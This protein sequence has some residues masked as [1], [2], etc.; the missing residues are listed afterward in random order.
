MPK[1]LDL[2]AVEREELTARLAAAM[3]AGDE[4]EAAQAMAEFADTIQQRILAEA[5]A[6]GAEQSADKAVLASRGTRVLT[7]S[8]EKY[9]QQLITAMSG[10]T[11]KVKQALTDIEIAMPTTVIDAVFED[12]QQAHPLLNLVDFR[13]TNGIVK[14]IVNEGGIQLAVWGK[15]TDAFKTELSGGISEIDTSLYKLQA[16]L[17]V[18]KAMLDLGPVWLDRYV[19]AILSEAIAFGVED[20][21]VTGDGKD[22]PIGMTRV[23]GKQAVVSDGV[24]SEKEA[25]KITSIDPVSYGEICSKLAVHSENGRQRVVDNLILVVSPVDYLKKIMPATTMLVNGT[26]IRDIFPLPT[27]VA[28]SQK[29]PEGEAILGMAKRYFFALGTPKDGRIEYDDSVQFMEDARVYAARLY[30]NGRPLDNNAFLRL[31]ISE[32]KPL[33]YQVT[34]YAESLDMADTTEG[35]AEP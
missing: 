33:R 22:K 5:Q 25:L 32:L 31:D 20:A 23:V 15:L 17:P 30:G 4:T 11:H 7:S 29:C 13:N 34:T 14:M 18:A 24:Y 2:T 3:T 12:I 26:Y 28:Q 21:I 19:R 35:D 6:M 10:S 1:S 9:Y 27:T 16:Y 8:E